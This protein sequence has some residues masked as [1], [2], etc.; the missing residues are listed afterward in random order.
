M[1]RIHRAVADDTLLAVAEE[2]IIEDAALGRL[3]HMPVEIWVHLAIKLGFG[4]Q[5]GTAVPA[6]W[7]HGDGELE[8][9]IAAEG[10]CWRPRV[11]VNEW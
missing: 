9:S 5:P 6:G 11:V 3:R 10:H 1:K 8:A 7:P 2:K 4:I